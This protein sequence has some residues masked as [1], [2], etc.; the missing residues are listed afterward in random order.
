MIRFVEQTP[1][2]FSGPMNLGN[3]G[4]FTVRELAK[5]VSAMI[6]GGGG[7]IFRELPADDPKVRRPDIAL[8]KEKIGWAPKV[9]LAE[10]LRKTIDYFMTMV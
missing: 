8:A 2:D 7:V 6:S 5:A 4:E 1:D 9:D 10:G 3:P